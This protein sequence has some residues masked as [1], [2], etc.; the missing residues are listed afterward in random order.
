MYIYIHVSLFLFQSVCI[1]ISESKAC[2]LCFPTIFYYLI[3]EYLNIYPHLCTYIYHIY[4]VRAPL[5]I[6]IA[7]RTH[8]RERCRRHAGTAWW[9]RAGMFGLELCAYIYIYMYIYIQLYN[10]YIHIIQINSAR[11]RYIQLCLMSASCL[12]MYV[13][14]STWGYWHIWAPITKLFSLAQLYIEILT[15]HFSKP[16]QQCQKVRFLRL[17]RLCASWSPIAQVQC[18]NTCAKRLDFKLHATVYT[19]VFTN[20]CMN[21]CFFKSNIYNSK[22]GA[23]NIKALYI[24]P[25]Y[26]CIYIE[27]CCSICKIVGAHWHFDKNALLPES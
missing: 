14:R 26:I 8:R 20:T 12:Q 6:E 23:I 4:K 13:Q 22:P 11:G 7:W 16:E 17:L 25:T 27:I 21:S 2:I 24:Y 5:R 9:R 1:K 10:I 15:Q 19:G 3:F 18:R